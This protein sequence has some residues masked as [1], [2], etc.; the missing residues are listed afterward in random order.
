MNVFGAVDTLID[1]LWTYRSNNTSNLILIAKLC[2]GLVG[3]EDTLLDL[4]EQK[5][6]VV[7][8]ITN[9]LAS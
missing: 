8:L 7:D 9:G 3:V 2:P 1:R 6:I 5:K 4:H